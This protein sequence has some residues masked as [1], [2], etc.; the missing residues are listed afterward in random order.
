MQLSLKK[1]EPTETTTKLSHSQLVEIAAKWLRGRMHCGAVL[2]ELGAGGGEIPDAIGW[3]G[4]HCVLIECKTS[5]S[6]FFADKD[7]EFRKKPEKGVGRLRFFLV[8]RG[9]VK[10]EEVPQGWG[11]LE[12]VGSRVRVVKKSDVFLKRNVKVEMFLMYTA[13]QRVSFRSVRPL[14]EV[15]KWGNWDRMELCLTEADLYPNEKFDGL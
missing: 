5:R 13:L 11:L 12:T 8:P 3:Q 6:D 2:T 7:K 4:T 1:E 14:H 15:V 10:F 9:L